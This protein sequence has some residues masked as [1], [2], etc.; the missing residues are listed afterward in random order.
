MA[1]MI[2][3]HID[4][5][6]SSPGE[7]EIFVRLRDDPGT[8]EWIVLHSLAVAQHTHLISGELDFVILIPSKGVLVIEVKACSK[9]ARKRGE[10]FYGS[11]TKGDPRGPFKQASEAM[12]S[13]RRRVTESRP[14]LSRIAFWSAVLFPYI[15]F[16]ENSGEW[17]PWQVID[18]SIFQSQPLSRSLNTVL[19]KA[20]SYLATC[21]SA[22]WFVPSSKE[23]YPEQ[24]DELAQLLR[25]DFEIFESRKSRTARLT[26]E[27]KHYTKEQFGALDVMEEN[28][29]V[30]FAG[31]AGTGKTM[32]A[33]EAAYR[34]V[35]RGNRV[36]LFCFNKLLAKWLQ[37]QT[38]DLKPLLATNTI[39]AYM[40]EVASLPVHE[41]TNFWDTE[42]PL[43][44]IDKLLEQDAAGVFDEL[45]VDEAQDILT[46]NYLDFLDLN[47][48][49]GLS[50]GT[51]RFFGD[52]EKQAIYRS[53]LP[54]IKDVLNMRAPD[55]P[56][57]ALRT[58]CRNTP[59]VAELA[60]LL[61]G[62][63]PN[64]TKVLR[65]DDGVEP[66]YI[67]YRNA[68]EQQQLL[69]SLLDALHKENYSGSDIVILS[70]KAE[71]SCAS[72]LSAGAWRERLEPA[73]NSGSGRIAYSSIHAFKGLEA[74]VV[75]VT[76]VEKISDAMAAS[77]FY[78]AVT[79][80]LLRLVI[81][82]KDSIKA[83]LI[84]VITNQA[85]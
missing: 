59:R 22:K 24:C 51:W 1:R 44:A 23:P 31:P 55:V 25:A 69:T 32:L 75:I 77:L 61:G 84:N 74:P 5:Q 60:R 82:I 14:D 2:P 13:L 26:E 68:A 54:S 56:I 63:N 80:S 4:P 81:F 40:L 85:G 9:L 46:N 34:A 30:V 18:R 78:V 17:H 49:G 35:C 36:L 52:F 6:C 37:Q 73:G 76:D 3:P 48:K 64:Y 58:N 12:H 28:P 45:I 65:P 42:V 67:Y 16:K 79:R 8:K 20:R 10:W 83:E 33:I 43:A 38:A 62:L 47:L 21:A 50:S 41:G 11:N 15:P 72:S 27:L 39:H 66:E 53:S 57:Y 7:K 29:R 70:T 19:D 71:A